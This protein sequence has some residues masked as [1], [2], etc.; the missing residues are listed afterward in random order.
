MRG[1]NQAHFA[2]APTVF[3]E[4][5]HFNL[6]CTH[7]TTFNAGYLIPVFVE[8]ILPGDTFSIR[9]QFFARLA[10]A[11][12]TP[13][14]DN[15]YLDMQAWFIPLRLVWDNFEKFTGE[16]DDPDDDPGDYVIPTIST[17]AVTGV[18]TH[19]LFDYF[20]GIP[21]GVPGLDINALIPRAYNLLW[22][23]WYRHQKIQYSAPFTKADSGDSYSD[24]S[25]RRRCKRNDYFTSC[26]PEPQEDAGV[27]IPLGTSAPVFGNEYNIGL[28]THNGSGADTGYGANL[29]SGYFRPDE[30]AKGAL[31]SATITPS[32]YPADNRGLGVI[33]KTQAGSHPEYSGMY[34]DLS[35]ATAATIN[36]LRLAFAMQR[37]AETLARAGNRYVEQLRAI[38][39]VDCPDYR[40]Q[41]PE[42]LG[43]SS[44]LINTHVVAQTNY[45]GGGTTQLGDVGAFATGS[46]GLSVVKSFVEH[47]YIMILASVRADMTYQ[48]GLDRMWTRATYY[49]FYQPPFA[50]IGEEAI[51]TKEIYCDGTATDETV[52]GY[53]EYG[54]RYRYK[55]N[56]IT[57][58]FRSDYSSS[59]DTWHLAQDFG[60]T[61][62]ELDTTFIAE[63]PPIDRVLQ[64]SSAGG[65]SPQILFDSLW[66]VNAA[67]RMPVYS[68][69][70]ELDHH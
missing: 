23:K 51:L 33:T 2:I 50:H 7:K 43:G 41:R 67:R 69:P 52:F 36:S 32:G 22:N 57:G 6:S 14:M 8:E 34:A 66:T 13:I 27:T 24:Y 10:S 55:P 18:V 11:L 48:R 3:A 19:D 1:P 61:A 30:A 40:L 29:T 31:V 4:R 16:K 63:N 59:L 42:Y 25:L 39:Q 9:G 35:T 5:S 58:M 54:A 26:L 46:G 60:A 28:W 65:T 64:V 56:V 17:P 47:G 44:D 68:I 62:P 37:Y 49:D 38:W 70:G 45:G 21:I 12:K 20:G 53:Q 15:I